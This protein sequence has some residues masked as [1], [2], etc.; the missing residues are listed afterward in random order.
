MALD[1]KLKELIDKAINSGYVQGVQGETDLDAAKDFCNKL[2]EVYK[3]K[4]KGPYYFPLGK[5]A[6]LE[7]ILKKS[8]ALVGA[9]DSLNTN[10]GKR[11]PPPPA[12]S[13]WRAPAGRPPVQPPQVPQVGRAPA[14]APVNQPRGTKWKP[15]SGKPS[16][17]TLQG[18]ISQAIKNGYVQKDLITASGSNNALEIGKF[19][20]EKLC[21]TLK[22]PTAEL[23]VGEDEQETLD[24]IIDKS[25]ELMAKLDNLNTSKNKNVDSASASAQETPPPPPA[26]PPQVPQR[27]TQP[28]PPRSQP[29][30]QQQM[31]PNGD[32]SRA[33]GSQPAAATP[34]R[35][36]R[37]KLGPPPLPATQG[38]QA[39]VQPGGI[40]TPNEPAIDI[41]PPP[42]D[43]G[44]FIPPPPLSGLPQNNN[45]RFNTMPR[46]ESANAG[47]HFE[48]GGY[49][50]DGINN[51]ENEVD[52]SPQVASEPS[53]DG[54]VSVDS[55]E[56][57][58]PKTDDLPKKSKNPFKWLGNKIFNGKKKDQ[59]ES[60]DQEVINLRNQLLGLYDLI[61]SCKCA[62]NIDLKEIKV[63]RKTL[64]KCRNKGDVVDKT[65]ELIFQLYL[66]TKWAPISIL[67]EEISAEEISSQIEECYGMVRA[68]SENDK[69]KI[70]EFVTKA[71]TKG[72]LE[73]KAIGEAGEKL[74]NC[75]NS[76]NQKVF[77]DDQIEF[78]PPQTLKDLLD[79]MRVL[80][81]GLRK[82]FYNGKNSKENLGKV[83]GD[84]VA[85]DLLSEKC[86]SDASIPDDELKSI[87]ESI[88][89]ILG[90]AE[91]FISSLKASEEFF[92][93]FNTKMQRLCSAFNERVSKEEEITYDPSEAGESLKTLLKKISSCWKKSDLQ[94]YS[95]KVKAA[96]EKLG[97]VDTAVE[98]MKKNQFKEVSKLFKDIESL[99]RE[100]PFTKDKAK[101]RQESIE[102]FL[103]SYLE[104][105]ETL[106]SRTIQVMKNAGEKEEVASLEKIKFNGEVS[107]Y[108]SNLIMLDENMKKVCDLM[109]KKLS[110]EGE[111]VFKRGWKKLDASE[112]T[113][114][115]K[116]TLKKNLKCF[117]KLVSMIEKKRK[118]IK[119][120]NENFENIGKSSVEKA[121]RKLGRKAAKTGKRIAKTSKRLGE[122]LSIKLGLKKVE[123]DKTNVEKCFKDAGGYFKKACESA[124]K[125]KDSK[126][127]DKHFT[128]SD[129]IKNFSILKKTDWYKKFKE[130]LNDKAIKAK[131]GNKGSILA[132]KLL[133]SFL[134]LGNAENVKAACNALLKNGI[135]LMEKQGKTCDY[136]KSQ[137]TGD[138]NRGT[139]YNALK[140]KLVT[141]YKVIDSTKFDNAANHFTDDLW[142]DPAKKSAP[143]AEPEETKQQQ[144]G[145]DTTGY[146]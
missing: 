46:T 15:T 92:E 119:E 134:G 16:E 67:C 83:D 81:K 89:G 51:N 136:V 84:R 132:S 59:E 95:G 41:P 98:Y 100:L 54:S 123:L 13:P 122:K 48:N 130:M 18:R 112:S 30:F 115:I 9:L 50:Q 91:N 126:K 75:Y 31:S 47:V 74:K 116:I 76:Y 40:N 144:G 17:I 107:R 139:V 106:S 86:N 118:D 32:N 97:K 128:A 127:K 131:K 23:K 108:K 6:G 62:G 109:V 58:T 2:D 70:K 3:G 77:G 4:G 56:T 90:R 28:A 55:K 25:E 110:R 79:E 43:R 26:G 66:A 64:E 145:G 53:K 49:P 69:V 63:D 1:V 33:Q 135:L 111:Y 88:N 14:A 61:E 125:E 121:A 85:I 12:N 65:I 124:E 45:N 138:V 133:I 104:R 137:C 36:P 96:E 35:E 113:E 73:S 42:G 129:L 142:P 143:A 52:A 94:H 22:I 82:Y 103:E 7:D 37:V 34:T 10:E 114:N 72:F 57:D 21:E 27:T 140:K 146:F 141:D 87:F 93:I 20:Y 8:R 102:K 29:V 105:V 11:T 44:E 19:F 24:N 101:A 117:I 80:E 38:V 78:N 39:P 5:D 99:I 60:M 68:L 71:Q 120:L